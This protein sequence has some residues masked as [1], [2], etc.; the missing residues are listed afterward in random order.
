MITINKYVLAAVV[1]IFIAVGVSAVYFYWRLSGNTQPNPS[2]EVKRVVAQVGRLMVLPQGEDPTLATVVDP[3]KLKSQPFFANAQK[4]DRV[5]IYT[6][7]KKAILYNPTLNKIVEVAPIT[8]GNPP[9]AAA[10]SPAPTT[11]NAT[12]TKK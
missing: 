1:L 10:P 2:A 8:I 4:G 6:G 11:P 5:L 9:A 3:D 12:S 7:A